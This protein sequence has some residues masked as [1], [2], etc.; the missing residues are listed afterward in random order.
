MGYDGTD[1]EATLEMIKNTIHLS[2]PV[3]LILTLLIDLSLSPDLSLSSFT[4]V[5][6][7][8]CLLPSLPLVDAV[9]GEIKSIVLLMTKARNFLNRPRP[10]FVGDERSW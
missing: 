6:G 7:F 3:D 2:L 10:R 8:P 5:S 4:D 1:T 9:N